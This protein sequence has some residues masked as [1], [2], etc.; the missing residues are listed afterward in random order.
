MDRT[1]SDGAHETARRAD[2]RIEAIGC[3]QQAW[4]GGFAQGCAS[5]LEIAA[6]REG[7]PER[8]STVLRPMV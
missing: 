5:G 1:N 6:C 7:K 8:H 3:E 4:A 2:G